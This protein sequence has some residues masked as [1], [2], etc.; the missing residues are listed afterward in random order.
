L[1]LSI[2][3]RP[4]AALNLVSVAVAA[5]ILAGCSYSIRKVDNPV[6]MP[7]AWDA[8]SAS[9][10]APAG[11][12]A[13]PDVVVPQDW[14]RSFNSPVLDSLV[15]RALQDNPT[16]IAAE[17]RLGQAERNFARNRDDLFPELS[18]SARTSRTRSGG[19][20]Q[21]E[22]TN[23]STSVGLSTSYSVDLFGAQA[24]RYRAQV[25]SFIG[26]KYDTDLAR[27][28]LAQNVTRAYFNLLGVR[29]RVEVAREN[30]RIAEQILRIVDARY[31]NG[32]VREFDLS[33]QNTSV[34]QQR[35]NLIPLENQMRQAETALGLLLGITPQ[36]FRIEGEPIEELNVPEVAPWVPSEMLL[37]R[38]DMAAAELDMVA[39][40]ANLAAARASLIPVTLTLSA[41]GNAVS[42][43]LVSLTDART[44]SVGGALAIAEGIF[45]FRQRR[46]NVLNA[47]SNEY[48]ALITYAQTIRQALKEVD[49]TLAT[50]VANQRAEESQRATLAQAQRALQLAEVEYREGSANL[51]EVLD[52]QRSLFSAQDSLLQARLTRLNTAVNLY[53]ALGGGWTAPPTLAP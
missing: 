30:L 23:D 52:S 10:T 16:L 40:K 20:Q 39:A 2:A 38:P 19:N 37:R 33:Q 5:A 32:V 31:R 42:S 48:I 45:N 12:A 15:E 34:L 29:S 43:D 22:V 25:A 53:V 11:A 49:D 24:A 1:S 17:E 3:S 44:F 18:L 8:S 27:I 36:E 41:S 47:E 6:D 28:T 51:Q 7:A 9:E 35:T 13:V 4:R 50:A 14:W 26:T 46:T 21:N